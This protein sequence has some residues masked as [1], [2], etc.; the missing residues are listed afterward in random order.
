MYKTLT[1]CINC[2]NNCGSVSLG[3]KANICIFLCSLDCRGMD[4]SDDGDAVV[5]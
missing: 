1:I 2:L 3:N 5:D 4:I